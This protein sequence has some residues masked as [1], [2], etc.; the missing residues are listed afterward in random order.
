MI[1]LSLVELKGLYCQLT[2]MNSYQWFM[3]IICQT[4]VKISLYIITFQLT[5]K[6]CYNVHHIY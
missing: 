6:K 5:Q 4:L 2:P 3:P 1:N